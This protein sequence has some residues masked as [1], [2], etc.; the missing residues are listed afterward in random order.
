MTLQEIESE[1]LTL[2]ALEEARR[3]NWRSVRRSAAFLGVFFALGG[4]GIEVAGLIIDL[5]SSSSQS[6]VLQQTGLMFIL[7]AL[8]MILLRT[9]LVD[10]VVPD[11]GIARG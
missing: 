8:P 7:F 6:H 2:R 9:A 11:K 3:K 5:T 1:L 4:G 10:P